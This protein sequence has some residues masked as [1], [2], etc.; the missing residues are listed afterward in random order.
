MMKKTIKLMALMLTLIVLLAACG[1]RNGAGV[2]T[3]AVA[4]GDRETG[5]TQ[6]EDA[7][8]EYPA[9]ELPDVTGLATAEATGNGAKY[10]YPA[11]KW[12]LDEDNGRLF[13]NDT[14]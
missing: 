2:N 14:L 1:G 4:G 12:S 6:Q 7:G 11:D 3:D 5:S 10:S 9:L 13:Y 8:S